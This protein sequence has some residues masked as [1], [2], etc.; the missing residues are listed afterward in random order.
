MAS[1]EEDAYWMRLALEQARQAGD[2]GEVPVGAVLVGPKQHLLNTGAEES[3]ASQPPSEV[4]SGA[5]LISAGFNC[6]IYSNDPTAH[7]E[8]VTIRSA[9]RVLQNYRLPETTLYVTIEP[10]SMCVGAMV[11]ARIG[12]LVYGAEEPRA[13]AVKSA[14]RLLNSEVFNHKLQVYSGVLAQECGELMASFFREKRRQQKE[15]K[16]SD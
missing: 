1:P 9:G 3:E 10:C 4:S 6:P 16:K 2:L 7:A 14:M 5:S 15:L 8:I 11:H 12:R 13:G